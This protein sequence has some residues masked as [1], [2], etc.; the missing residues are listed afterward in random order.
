LT[1][2]EW[3]HNRVVDLQEDNLAVE[4]GGPD[5]LP[6]PPGIFTDVERFDV[7]VTQFAPVS[8]D[9]IGRA[10]SLKAI[11]VLR[12]GTENVAVE[13][14]AERGVS[15][16]NAPGRN[17]NAVAEFTVGMILAET[18]N[19]ARSDA[20]LRAGG[21]THAFPNSDAIHELATRTVGIVGLGQIGY[22]VAELVSAFGARVRYHDPFAVEAAP[23]W[24]RVGSVAELAATSDILSLNARLT[25][26]TR[27]L[28]SAEVLAAMPPHAVLVNTARSGLI[29]ESALVQALQRRQITGAAIDTF[30][31]EPLPADSPFLGL[32][33]VTITSHLAGTT[34]DAFDRSPRILAP[35]LVAA[36]I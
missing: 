36:L 23:G 34:V 4:K 1:V 19:I 27:H 12:G 32:D 11:G 17:A 28:V 35:R 26:A 15:V 16:V 22:R 24:E 25:P 7:I 9:V 14:A 30:D 3:T 20:D 13:A 6:E 31:L 5:A 8:A 10:T 29:D 18:R 21:W 2:R 33:N